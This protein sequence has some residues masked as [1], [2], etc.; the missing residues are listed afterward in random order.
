MN[1]LKKIKKKRSGRDS[2]GQVSVRHQGAEHKK[3]LRTI[4]FR[5]NNKNVVGRVIAFEYDPNRSVDLAL[6]KFSDGDTRY[7]LKPEGLKLNDNVVSSENA[8]IKTGNT[9]PLSGIPIG[10][11][12][13]NIELTPGKGGQLARSAGTYAIIAAREGNFVHLKMPSGEIRKIRAQGYATVGTLGNIDWKNRVFRKA[14]TKRHMGIRPTVRGVAQNPRSH[15]HGGGEGRS[16]IGM[17]LPKT[18][19]GRPAVGKTRKKKKYSNKYILQR[20]KK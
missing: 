16:G 5:R 19:A 18:Y 12:V 4:D 20:R 15:P 17:S 8:D 7:I 11:F 9:L 3:F 6:I 13:H 1:R 14:G 10:T 2:S